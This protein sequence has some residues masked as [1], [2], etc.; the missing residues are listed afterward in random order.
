MAIDYI[1]PMGHDDGVRIANALEI[2]AGMAG[3][4]YDRRCF[5]LDLID[6]RSCLL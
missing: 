4:V 3:L 1:V 6:Y 2:M 5:F